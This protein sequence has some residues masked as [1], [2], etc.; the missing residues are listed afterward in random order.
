MITMA[1]DGE[2]TGVD[3]FHGTEPFYF[4]TAFENGQQQNF[5]WKVDPLTRE[6][7]VEP[8]DVETLRELINKADRIIGQ[9]LKFDAHLLTTIGIELPFEKIEDTLIASHVLASGMPHDLM[10]L[11]RQYLPPKYDIERFEKELDEA[12][13]SAR[14][15]C[16]SHLKDWL[17]AREGLPCMPSLKEKPHKYDLWLSLIHI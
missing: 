2:S 15:Y 3:H 9:N 4:T 16:R 13:Q 11:V 14:R 10:N 5:E 1:L 12:A 6:V 8:E 7:L 17:I